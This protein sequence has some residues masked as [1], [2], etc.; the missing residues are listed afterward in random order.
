MV[1]PA[2][3]PQPPLQAPP[4]TQAP[5]RNPRPRPV[6]PSPAP[7]PRIRPRA[8]LCR[9]KGS[10][11][12]EKEDPGH[13]P[14][15]HCLCGEVKNRPG[16]CSVFGRKRRVPIPQ[17]RLGHPSPTSLSPNPSYLPFPAAA[18]HEDPS[19]PILKA[20][21]LLQ[22]VSGHWPLPGS[23]P[24]PAHAALRP[25]SQGDSYTPLK[26]QVPGAL[27]SSP[28]PLRIHSAPQGSAWETVLAA[29]QFILSW[30][31]L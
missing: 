8:R 21:S 27:L 30:A 9:P 16:L 3:L 19:G 4:H 17:S 2:S 12:G 23:S 29:A 15:V 14:S 26:A 22:T 24:A 1:L 25:G 20:L 31:G 11:E 6:L 18:A 10:G 13:G 5:P 7:H 28:E